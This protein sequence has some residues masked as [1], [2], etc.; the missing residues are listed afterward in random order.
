MHGITVPALVDRRPDV[1]LGHFVVVD[2]ESDDL[3]YPVDYE[4]LLQRLALVG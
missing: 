2:D 1:S 4:R 3:D